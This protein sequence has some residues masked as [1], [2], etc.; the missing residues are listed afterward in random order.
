MATQLRN[1]RP[2]LLALL[3]QHPSLEATMVQ[4]HVVV[5]HLVAAEAVLEPLVVPTLQA[6]A[7]DLDLRALLDARSLVGALEVN[8]PLL[9]L[10]QAVGVVVPGDNRNV[11]KIILPK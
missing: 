5:E 1:Q 4:S 3:L 10:V 6:V 11:D 7:L 2:H 9:C 8:P